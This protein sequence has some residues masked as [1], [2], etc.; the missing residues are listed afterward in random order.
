MRRYWYEGVTDL[1]KSETGD[2]TAADESEA[3]ERLR[4]MGVTVLRLSS[5]DL[6]AGASVPWYRRDIAFGCNRMSLTE[7]ADVAQQ[8]ALL[9]RAR[10]PVSDIIAILA[11]SAGSARLRNRYER[12]GKLVADGLP[13]A[14]AFA[15]S[16]TQASP[17]FIAILKFAD[18]SSDPADAIQSLASF[19]RRQDQAQRQLLGALIYPAILIAVAV[20]VF[21]LV[22]L[23]LAPNLAP[24]FEAMNQPVPV[25][26]AIFTAI[27]AFLT[28]NAPIL[29]VLLLA[30]TALLG[31][32]WQMERTGALRER[33]LLAAPI[34]GPIART[35]ELSRIAH[36]TAMLLRAGQT[37]PDALRQSA[38]AAGGSAYRALIDQSALDLENGQPASGALATD[39]TIP[40]TFLELFR[41]GEMTNSLT[42][43]LSTLAQGLDDQ[44]D[45]Q[46]DRYMKLLTPVITL[47]LGG[48]IALL[49]YSVMTAILS[50][51]DLAQ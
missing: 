43:V 20:G 15:Q 14:N 35:A 32:T 22:A 45:R 36:C 21:L 11:R 27:G 41:V 39:R 26:L 2:V 40:V 17:L 7:Q 42:Q 9:F 23:F 44:L 38:D 48:G 13:L 18:L 12:M 34:I 6:R 49:V 47:V 25:A 5:E 4:S 24:M 50:V 8:M 10:L 51:N 30:S 16:G 31:A 1:G 46:I 3:F 37:L 33:L 19:F 29:G 28:A